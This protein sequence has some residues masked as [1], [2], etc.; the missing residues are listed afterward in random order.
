MRSENEA[1]VTYGLVLRTDLNGVR[2]L[3]ELI[4]SE[5]MKLVFD[6]VSDGYLWIKEGKQDGHGTTPIR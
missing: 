4:E 5:G 6:R 1:W 2:K 3:R